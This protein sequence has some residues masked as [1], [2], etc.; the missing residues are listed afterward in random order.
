MLKFPKLVTEWFLMV[1]CHAEFVKGVQEVS[2]ENTIV[3]KEKVWGLKLDLF[4]VGIVD[5]H[6]YLKLML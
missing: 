1:T 3:N 5:I 6:I 2:P 4:R